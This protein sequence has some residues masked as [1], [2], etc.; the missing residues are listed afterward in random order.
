MDP[1]IIAGQASSASGASESPTVTVAVAAGERQARIHCQICHVLP[2]PELLPKTTWQNQV[3][4]RMKIRMGFAPRPGEPEPDRNLIEALKLVGLFPRQPMVSE[5]L[6]NTIAAYYVQSAPETPLPQDAH[7]EIKIGLKQF[8]AE[9]PKFRQAAPAT[10]MVKIS[11]TKHCIYCGDEPTQS[12]VTLDANGDLI[13]SLKLGNTPVSLTEGDGGLYLTA[14]GYLPPTDALLA[15]VLR[16]RTVG[17]TVQAKRIVRR[18]PRAVDAKFGDFNRDGRMDFALCMF[19]NNVGRFSW[20]EN[21]GDDRYVE[22]VLL[23]KPGAIQCAVHDFNGDGYP[24]L[25]VLVTQ[26]LESLFIF[27]N[28]GHGNFKSHTVF[29]RPP[30]WGHSYFELA[31]FNGDGQMDLLVTN[32]DNADEEFHPTL[33]KYH[34]IR[35]YLNRGN[36][37]FEEAFFFPLNGAYKAVARDFQ[38]NGRLDIAAISC[39]PDYDH[40]PR[41]SFVYLENL[42]GLRFAPST[43]RE[44]TAGRW[45][46]MDVGDLDGDG[47]LD[48]VLGSFTPGPTAV[49]PALA[50]A[51]KQSGPPVLILRNTLHEKAPSAPKP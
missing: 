22:H 48:I 14:I 50:E 26:A 43:F 46:T 47:D 30:V 6:W 15:E 24:D 35:I 8:R 37:R 4:P 1:A 9:A 40:A 31:D 5:S 42:G 17:D 36:L 18:V 20:F 29:Q 2:G 7:A 27:I 16:L 45:L 33:K 21:L 51:W 19:G 3:L 10:T 41:E 12:L 32:G 49:P 39:F 25:A 28:D 38:G 44:C 34:G 13:G 11:E 23:D